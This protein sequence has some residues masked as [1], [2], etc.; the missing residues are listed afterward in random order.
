[1]EPEPK[2]DYVTPMRICHGNIVLR[3]MQESDIDDE[4][5]WNTE[6]TEWALWDAPWEMEVELP[7]FNPEKYRAEQLARLAEPKEKFRWSFA[8]DTGGIHVGSVSS[9]L[10]DENWEWIRRKDVKPEQI[11]YHTLGIEICES[12]HWGMGL[13]TKFLAAFIRYHLE[14]GITDLCLQ[15]WS[16]NI[17]M[18]HVAEKVGFV[19]CNREVNFRKVR[20]C[21]Y[22][23]LTF[24][25]NV[26]KFKT[27]LRENP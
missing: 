2:N 5:R 18:I 13:G 12:Q 20:G 4:I 6:E 27:F 21:H 3:D 25:L 26:E 7:K 15:T 11:T 23:G 8:L 16:G 24:R 22:D 1:M 9:Y 17:R 14:N 10:I 19:E